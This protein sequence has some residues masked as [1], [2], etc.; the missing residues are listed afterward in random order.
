MKETCRQQ[1]RTIQQFDLIVSKTD[2]KDGRDPWAA[3]ETLR[4]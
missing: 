1:V 4:M 3:L 2:I